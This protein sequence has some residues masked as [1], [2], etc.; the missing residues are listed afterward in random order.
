MYGAPLRY[1]DKRLYEKGQL[2]M[3]EEVGVSD[4]ALVYRVP[5]RGNLKRPGVWVL[6]VRRESPSPMALRRSI[7]VA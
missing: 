2:Q 3:L 6:R 1:E 7:V 5:R 4:F